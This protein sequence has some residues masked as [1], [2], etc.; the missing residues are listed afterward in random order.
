MA[1]PT[2]TPDRETMTPAEVG[3]ALGVHERTV[4]RAVARGELAGIKIG[5]RIV[6]PRH[7]IRSAL[8]G[9]LQGRDQ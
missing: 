6:I 4:R 7:V 8:A 2:D 1:N 5:R 3:A 9:Q